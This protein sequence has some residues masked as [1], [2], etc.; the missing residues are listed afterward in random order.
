MATEMKTA[1][2]AGGSS[3]IGFAIARNMAASGM[4]VTIAGRWQIA[5]WA[6]WARMRPV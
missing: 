6:S 1:L 3:G 4:R 2:V 5:R